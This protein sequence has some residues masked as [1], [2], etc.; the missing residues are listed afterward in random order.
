MFVCQKYL[1]FLV[2]KSENVS[3]KSTV[4][5]PKDRCPMY[6][7]DVGGDFI[8]G[9]GKMFFSDTWEDCGK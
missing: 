6:D 9:D 8:D 5:D 3:H 2:L 4:S 7:E 1:S